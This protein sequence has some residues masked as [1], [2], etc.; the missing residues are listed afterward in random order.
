MSP[1]TTVRR[2]FRVER[3]SNIV[4]NLRGS[5]PRLSGEGSAVVPDDALT[6]GEGDGLA[7]L[8]NLEGLGCQHPK[9]VRVICTFSSV[10]RATDS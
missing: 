7:V 10:G 4:L 2:K 5:S 8:G 3:N 1:F 9:F 6:D